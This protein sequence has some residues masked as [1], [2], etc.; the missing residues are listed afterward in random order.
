MIPRHKTR[1]GSKL[2]RSNFNLWIQVV[3]SEKLICNSERSSLESIVS[4]AK[5]RFLR[6]TNKTFRF[7]LPHFK[8]PV[9]N[10]NPRIPLD[11]IL[12]KLLV[13][14]PRLLQNCHISLTYVNF[15]LKLL[16]R[17]TGY[18]HLQQTTLYFPIQKSRKSMS[19]IS[20]VPK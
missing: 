9:Q 8:T 1:K 6:Q 12:K 19:R 18:I 11:A 2:K 13:T 20:S 7:V 15:G 16:D 5:F 3:Y 10:T 4:V 17:M 14:T